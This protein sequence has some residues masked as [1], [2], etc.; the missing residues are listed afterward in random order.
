LWLLSAGYLAYIVA[1]ELMN[2]YS[3]PSTI[4][5][6][7]RMV[8]ELEFPAVTICNLATRNKSQFSNDTR[9][10]NYHLRLSAIRV[11]S[12]PINWTDPFYLT[13]NYFQ[14]RT[15]DDLYN[16]SKSVSSF[17][18][19]HTFDLKDRAISITPIATDLGLC[20]RANVNNTLSTR[21]SGGLYNLQMYLN[22]FLDDDYYANSYLSSGVKVLNYFAL[23]CFNYECT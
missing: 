21:L 19:Y 14:E 5:V 4:T 16:E 3:Y 7:V 12:E 2:Y 10:S 20:I 22:L 11:G 9:T 13:E 23:R 15:M 18:Q 6:T 8:D 1:V 17:V